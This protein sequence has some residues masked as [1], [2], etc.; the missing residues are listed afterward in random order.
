MFSKKEAQL[1][2]TEFW[3]AFGKSFPRKWILYDTRIK[4]FSFKFYA[5]SKTAMV[6]LD[7]EMKDEKIRLAYLEKIKSLE[8][9]FQENIGE[10]FLADEFQLENGKI[11][12]KIWVEKREVSIYNKNTWQEIFLFFVEKMQGFETVFLEF[13]DYI[14]DVSV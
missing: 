2:T 1:L 7:L 13:E 8:N 3:T 4:D 9:F 6:S 12:S 11:I 10:Y 5:D 14:R